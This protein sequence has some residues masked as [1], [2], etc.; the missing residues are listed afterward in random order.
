MKLTMLLL[1]VFLSSNSPGG[2]GG[3]NYRSSPMSFPSRNS[4]T[5]PYQAYQSPS[6]HGDDPWLRYM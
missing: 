1:Q 5:A 6:H 2:V 4:F 3:I